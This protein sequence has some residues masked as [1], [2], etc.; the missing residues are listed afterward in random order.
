MVRTTGADELGPLIGEYG[1]D[2]ERARRNAVGWFVVGVLG[3]V[4]GV[5]AAIAYIAD[6]G[7]SGFS[8]LPG[9][10]LGVGLGGL[11][12]GGTLLTLSVIRRRE[13]FRLH[14]G[15]LVHRRADAERVLAWQDI[16]RVD[17]QENDR[18]P[19][20]FMGTDVRCRIHLRTGG[21]ISVTGYHDGAHRLGSTVWRAVAK[22]EPPTAS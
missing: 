21:R 2:W 8:P 12:V 19:A 13:V 11:T 16:A 10:L 4:I 22:D 5:P 18:A 20:R 9:A 7:Q 3:T 14:Q 6:T 17:Y 15:G 1:Y